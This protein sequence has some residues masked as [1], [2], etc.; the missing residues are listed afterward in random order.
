[1]KRPRW[2]ASTDTSA[3]T[4]GFQRAVFALLSDHRRGVGGHH[5]HHLLKR[6]PSASI[7]LIAGSG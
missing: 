6:Q 5:R 7:E 1:M 4:P 2:S 3:A